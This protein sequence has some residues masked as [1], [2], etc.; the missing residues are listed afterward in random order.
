[1]SPDLRELSYF[2]EYDFELGG[3][4][5]GELVR[6][7]PVRHIDFRYEYYPGPGEIL[8]FSI[9]QK[10]F[11]RPMEIYKLGDN[12]VYRLKN[13]AC[14]N[15]LGF[16]VEMRKSMGFTKVP[17]L[18]N[19]TLYGNFTALRSKVK[20]GFSSIGGSEDGKYLIVI[21][22]VGKEEKRPQTGVSNYMV[23]A[24]AYYETK[25]FS[26]SLAYNYVTNR[27]YRPVELYAESLY[28]RPLEALDGQIAFRFFRQKAEL[29]LSVSNLLNSY[30]I[31][32]QNTYTAEELARENPSTKS[33]LYKKGQDL[34]DYEARPG[35][36][37]STT[38][39][40]SF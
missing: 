26:L 13:N 7:T 37:Y 18:K 36:T 17:V 39:S 23:N 29:R 20:T 4:Y 11:K 15:N 30:S 25:R 8:S 16:E 32:Y 9:F 24:G 27:M 6:S 22:S 14:A 1:M 33:L 40:F 28:E 34:I 5:I 31:V 2:G 35:R 38:L 21:D 19:I 10:E 3:Q 12:R